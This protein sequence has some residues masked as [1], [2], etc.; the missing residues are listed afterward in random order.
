MLAKS[1]APLL[2]PSVFY[3]RL[4]R[5][6][7]AI[8]LDMRWA[9]IT[10]IVLAGALFGPGAFAWQSDDEPVFDMGPG[11]TPPRVIHQVSPNPDSGSQGFRVSGTVLIGLVVTSL[12]MPKEVRVVRSLDKDL[13][14]NAVEAVQQW[15]F[16]PARK[17]NNP[18]AVR[19]TIEIRFR[20]L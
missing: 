20:D 4:H 3:L 14:K 16:E 10:A 19:I 7:I 11:I 13:D 15:L 9:I 1:F 12:G 2:Q 6:V 18:V 5:F 17:S 8:T